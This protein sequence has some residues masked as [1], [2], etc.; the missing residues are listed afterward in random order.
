MPKIHIPESGIIQAL[1]NGDTQTAGEWAREA[2]PA[3]TPERL[4]ASIVRHPLDFVCLPLY[5]NST[6]GLC[7]HVWPQ[8]EGTMSSVVHAHSWDLWS[9]VVCGTVFH[10]IMHI[11]D[12]TGDPEYL[13]YR[14]K[15]V[16]GIDEIRATKRLV[17]C[18][19]GDL[20]KVRA[21]QIYQLESGLFHRSGHQ[22][23]TATLVFGDHHEDRDNL[24]L[25][26]IDRQPETD[27]AREIC[28]PE[29]V[30]ELLRLISATAP[31]K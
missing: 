28:S 22:G 7:L 3:I 18:T 15:N 27:V 25:G 17:T 29:E 9:Y 6:E 24:V 10:Q 8:D 20:Q 26:P 16:G 23:L 4:P 19:P 5:R 30:H 11:H 14:A 2:L 13:V 21:G 12:D 31:Q 1:L